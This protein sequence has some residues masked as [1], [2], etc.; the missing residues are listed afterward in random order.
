M[1]ETKR[2]QS[3]AILITLIVLVSVIV[4]FFV[5][6]PL[7]RFVSDA[8]AFR[9]WVEANTWWSRVAYI[10]ML[11]IQVVFAVIPGGV[12]EVAAGYAFGAIEGTIL[13]VIGTT[14]GSTMVFILVKRYG[15]KYVLLFFTQEQLDSVK[16]MHNEKRLY[17]IVFIAFIIPGTPKDLLCYVAGLTDMKL[18][19]WITITSIARI[20][21][22]T[23]STIGGNAIGTES[24]VFA[25]GVFVFTLILSGIGV[26]VYRHITKSE[27][28]DS[29][30]S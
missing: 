19:R 21:A 4:L 29:S 10:G 23:I 28:D 12:F 22:I 15:L 1:S 5:G 7:I 3:M 11:V 2:K 18:S 25:A 27:S 26:L 16:F 30:E 24:Y 20:P 17:L 6:K 13:S 8:E 9:A 14:L